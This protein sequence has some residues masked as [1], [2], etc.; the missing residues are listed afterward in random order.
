MC[1]SEAPK[2]LRYAQNDKYLCVSVSFRGRETTEE[3]S[4]FMFSWIHH[5]VLD[6]D[7]HLRFSPSSARQ[8]DS[9]ND[10]FFVPLYERG[11]GEAEGIF[12]HHT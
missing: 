9:Q 8:A 5:F 7:L 10:I 4:G 2:I 12:T 3:S 11:Y 1:V 6:D